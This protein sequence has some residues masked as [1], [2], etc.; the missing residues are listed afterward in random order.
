MRPLLQGLC[1][2][3]VQQS[4]KSSLETSEDLLDAI[5]NVGTKH[6]SLSNLWCK[7]LFNLIGNEETRRCN[8]SLVL[9]VVLVN[10]F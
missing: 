2:L 1:F 10:S 6:K 9:N 8:D 5:I 7:I 4:F 3:T